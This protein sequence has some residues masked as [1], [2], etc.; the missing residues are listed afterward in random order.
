MSRNRSFFILAILGAAS[1]ACSL[2]VDSN[3]EQCK[4]T[5]DCEA[6]GSG[7]VCRDNL[8]Q[9]PVEGTPDA[10]APIDP[11][12]ACLDG[13]GI[14]EP[15]TGSVR[16]SIT[17]V[18]LL[19]QKP[20]AGVN[21]SLCA[22]LD[23]ACELPILPLYQSSATGQ[24]EVEMPAGFNGYFQA[25]GAGIYPTLIFP[26]STRRQRAPSTIPLVPDSFYPTMVKG[27]GAT[28]AEG[29]SVVITTAL[30]CLGRPAAGL[31][32][33]SP[34]AD[35]QT[36]SY[37]LASGVPSRTSTTTDESGGGGFVN[38]PAGPILIKSTLAAGDR[39]VGV[40]GVQTR[41]GHI[42]MVLIMPNGT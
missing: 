20:L 24:L 15:A 9:V 38:V 40:A 3:R 19:S 5:I 32:L 31:A 13:V 34:D 21:L 33:S 10:Q 6:F 14:S 35:S 1:S 2:Y 30:D 37:V 7:Y 16:V 29:R 28:V 42:S 36:V 27:S 4:Q 17:L 12:W 8:C 11:T 18:D 22:K 39:P 26:P 41:P 23:G 25:S